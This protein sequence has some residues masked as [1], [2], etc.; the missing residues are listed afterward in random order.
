M[1]HTCLGMCGLDRPLQ[2]CHQQMMFNRMSDAPLTPN[3]GQQAVVTRPELTLVCGSAGG[4]KNL[5]PARLRFVSPSASPIPVVKSGVPKPQPL[6]G[7]KIAVNVLR[8]AW[9]T[10]SNLMP[11][12]CAPVIS[13]PAA[14]FAKHYQ[15]GGVSGSL[16]L[17]TVASKW[18][19]LENY[20]LAL[21]IQ[22]GQQAP[23]MY[24][25]SLQQ[26]L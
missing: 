1:V 14:P 15:P 12:H 16:K 8:G 13:S 11:V 21:E 24:Y 3:A 19:G 18:F 26:T 4:W 17:R 2:S 5:G 25:Y 9:N 7:V 23:K 20:G 10:R 22:C 6:R